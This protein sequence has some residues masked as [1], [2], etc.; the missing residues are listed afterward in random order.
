MV[1]ITTIIE[2]LITLAVALVTAFFIPWLKTKI[3]AAKLAEL[4]KWVKIAVQAAEMIYTESGMGKFKKNYVKTFLESKGYT[5]DDES[6]DVLIESAV[7][8]LN[9][10][11]M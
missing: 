11:L 5:Y 3:D 6:I 9:K 2:A 10:G 1:D 4:D 7:L 8:A